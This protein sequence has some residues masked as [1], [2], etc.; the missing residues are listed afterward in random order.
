M[1][2]GTISGNSSDVGGGVFVEDGTFTMNGGEI[3]EN[4]AYYGDGVFVMPPNGIFIAS[5]KTLVDPSNAVCLYY[6][7]QSYR[8]SYIII[9]EGFD[10]T[11]ALTSIDLMG[12]RGIDDLEQWDTELLLLNGGVEL[13]RAVCSRF[14]FRTLFAWDS[15]FDIGGYTIKTDGRGSWIPQGSEI[16]SFTVNGRQAG[17]DNTRI[18]MVVPFDTTIKALAP[19]ITLAEGASV[20]P[21]SGETVDFSNPVA[22]TVTGPGGVKKVYTVILTPTGNIPSGGIVI[23]DRYTPREIHL[24]QDSFI[25]R[26]PGTA[27]TAGML[28]T[29]CAQLRRAWTLRGMIRGNTS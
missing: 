6:D 23:V 26:V 28:T 9:D 7:P 14:K 8:Y 29:P 1:D 25:I 12:A 16:L 13:P 11:G 10:T 24:E 18:T 5:G 17:I 4:T 20:C 2:G 21:A 15:D 19:E 22:Y 27:R 3:G